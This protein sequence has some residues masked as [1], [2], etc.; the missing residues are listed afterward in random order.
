VRPVFGRNETILRASRAFPP[1]YAIVG[2]FARLPKGWRQEQV[3]G[4]RRLCWGDV[5]TLGAVFFPR[6]SVE[7]LLDDLLPARESV[8]TAHRVIIR[9]PCEP[10]FSEEAGGS[11]MTFFVRGL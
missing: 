11:L 7:I 6:R 3:T 9:A 4:V 5:L 2:I 10:M 8:A 1:G